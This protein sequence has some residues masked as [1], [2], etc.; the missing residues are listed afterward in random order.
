[1]SAWANG[2]RYQ[3]DRTITDPTFRA[4][5]VPFVTRLV[6]R[7]FTGDAEFQLIDSYIAAAQDLYEEETNSSLWPQTRT[8]TASGFP[9]GPFELPFGPVSAVSSVAYYDSDVVTAYGGSPPSWRFVPTGLHGPATLE[10]GI[11]EIWPSADV[12]VD[13]V[14]ITYSAGYSDPEDVPARIKTGLA[15]VAGELYKNPD[16][17]N[18]MAQVGNLLKLDHFWRK[19]Y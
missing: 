4:I 3:T 8:L 16:L 15:L 1:M 6:L 11:N 7:A 12:R 5:D 14:T 13:A 10:P 19:R 2:I 9:C 17:S 18:D